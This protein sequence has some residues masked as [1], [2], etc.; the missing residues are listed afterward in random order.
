MIVHVQF[1][2]FIAGFSI[3]QG[4]AFRLVYG[5]DSFGNTC[6]EDNTAR[7]IENVTLSGMN[8]KGRP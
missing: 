4:D 3:K 2:V 8:M 6:D 5:Y 1:Q 7:K